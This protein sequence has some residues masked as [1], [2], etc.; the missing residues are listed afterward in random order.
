M[1][2]LASQIERRLQEETQLQYCDTDDNGPTKRCGQI[3]GAERVQPASEQKP[4]TVIQDQE[5]IIRGD[6]RVDTSTPRRK[7]Y[8]YKKLKSQR[9]PKNL[10]DPRDLRVVRSPSRLKSLCQ[11][12]QAIIINRRPSKP[13]S[14]GSEMENAQESPGRSGVGQRMR[15]RMSKKGAGQQRVLLA[16]AAGAAKWQG[17][18]EL[19]Q[20][21]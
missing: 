4:E 14:P 18:S 13:E 16:A 21:T 20:K 8:R 11:K 15:R 7:P 19:M 1:Q 2:V 9:N 12:A 17:T 5:S 3:K 6:Q 10:R